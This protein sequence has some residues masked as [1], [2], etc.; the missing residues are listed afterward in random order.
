VETYD[1]VLKQL[2]ISSSK[3]HPLNYMTKKVQLVGLTQNEGFN[4]ACGVVI[5]VKNRTRLCVKLVGD[6][7]IRG[8]KRENLKFMY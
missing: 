6:K 7:K 2:G 3:D 1:Q 8:V 4:G 5:G